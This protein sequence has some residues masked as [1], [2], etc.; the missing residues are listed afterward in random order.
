MGTGR[1]RWHGLRLVCYRPVKAV[2]GV[3]GTMER[4]MARSETG[5][6]QTR[7]GNEWGDG[8]RKRQM[9]RSENGMLQ[10]C[11]GS[12]WGDGYDGEANGEI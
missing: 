5:M 6:L 9:A 3:M 11:E 4:P 10:T 12:E 8:Y 1:G 7:E 2:S